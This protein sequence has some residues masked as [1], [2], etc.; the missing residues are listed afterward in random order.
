MIGAVVVSIVSI[1]AASGFTRPPPPPAPQAKG[2]KVGE[3]DVTLAAGAPQWKVLKLGPA[4]ASATRWSE[5]VP[6]RVKI[7]ESHAA[8]VG[9][10]LAGRVT[11]VLVELGQPVKLGDPLFTVASPDIAGLRSEREKAQVDFEITKERLARTRAMVEARAVPQKDELDADQQYRQAVLALKLSQSKLASLKVSSRAENEFTVVAPRDGV[12]VEKNVLPAQQIGSEP[13]LVSVADLSS[14]WVVADVF[15]ADAIGVNEGTAVRITSPSIPDLA[16]EAKVEMVS[17]VVDP[18]R[19]TIP[20]R[21]RLENDKLHLKPNVFAQM[22][23]SIAPA[24]GSVETAASAL[25]TDGAKQFVYVQSAE[26]HFTRRQV[27]A[28]SAREGK[29]PILSGLKADEV[30]VEEGAILLDNQIA[31]SR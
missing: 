3:D 16:I 26:G 21:V 2:M 25:V 28:G 11:H 12:I 5:P 1:V 7:D 20:V 4:K 30:V 18:A 6:A 24:E 8:R 10:P 31:L 15:E 17:A 14:V 9:S 29:V 19:H 22:R 13:S 23:F 27:V